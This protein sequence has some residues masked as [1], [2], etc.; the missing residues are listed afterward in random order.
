LLQAGG[1]IV[2]AT[3]VNYQT[4]NVIIGHDNDDDKTIDNYLYRCLQL[5]NIL[6]NYS[7]KVTP[8]FNIYN[9]ALLPGS[10]DYLQKQNL[11]QFEIDRDPEVICLFLSAINTNYLSYFDL[12]KKRLIMTK[13]IN[14][15]LIDQYDGVYY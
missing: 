7:S 14:D 15:S 6:L 12:F 13:E 3:T 2:L 9:R 8:Y 11:L 5:K 10:R 1:Q 4:F